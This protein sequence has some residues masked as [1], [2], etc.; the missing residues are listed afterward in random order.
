MWHLNILVINIRTYYFFSD[1]HAVLVLMACSLRKFDTEG[2]I[3]TTLDTS[4]DNDT[5]V[6]KIL[7]L[8][9]SKF[10]HSDKTF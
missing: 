4:E 6:N 8:E 9:H 2:R 10:S 1:N 7:N 5:K 3:L